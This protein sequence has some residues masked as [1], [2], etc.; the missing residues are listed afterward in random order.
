MK[1]LHIKLHDHHTIIQTSLRSLGFG[2]PKLRK[3]CTSTIVWLSDIK[4]ISWYKGR[5]GSTMKVNYTHPDSKLF[6]TELSFDWN[7]NIIKDILLF[8][9]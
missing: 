5:L 7:Q 2:R 4:V 9:W 3:M 8:K 1:K 6:E